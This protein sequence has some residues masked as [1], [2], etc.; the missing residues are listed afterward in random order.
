MQINSHFYCN[1]GC[2][3][4]SEFLIKAHNFQ[5]KSHLLKIIFLF[6]YKKRSNSM[7]TFDIN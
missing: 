5:T 6:I 1:K 3:S 2:V 7:Q 4:Y